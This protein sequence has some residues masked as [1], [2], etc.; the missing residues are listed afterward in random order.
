M[1]EIRVV[2]GDCRNRARWIRSRM[3]GATLSECRRTT[4]LQSIYAPRSDGHCMGTTPA[5]ER[6]PPRRRARVWRVALRGHLL[7]PVWPLPFAALL[8]RGE[9]A[10]V[11]HPAMASPATVE[12][13]GA[14]RPP[15]SPTGPASQCGRGKPRREMSG[16][17][18]GGGLATRRWAVA[19]RPRR[20][21][22]RPGRRRREPCA[23]TRHRGAA[24]PIWAGVG[25]GGHPIIHRGRGGK[26]GRGTR[27][28]TRYVPRS[29]RSA[30]TVT[31]QAL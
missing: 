6:R 1:N 8:R 22:A 12:Q 2:A 9:E 27:R 14:I 13:V 24:S 10:A 11:A 4:A 20:C 17:E 16:D 29:R 18:G 5:R 28:A 15:P 19:V 25:G 31:R 3:L 23:G 26:W 21:P 30:P 7:T